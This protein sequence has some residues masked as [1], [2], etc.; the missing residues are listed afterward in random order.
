MA[1][2]RG[3]A[4]QLD[5]AKLSKLALYARADTL[6][7]VTITARAGL[8]DGASF[9]RRAVVAVSP[10]RPLEPARIL[11]WEQPLDPAAGDEIS[12]R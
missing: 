10:D 3:G 8:P 5:A 6:H 7:V 1:S 2:R 11:R 12:L 9:T 4:T